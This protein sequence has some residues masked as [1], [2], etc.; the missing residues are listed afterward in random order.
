[1]LKVVLQAVGKWSQTTKS[2]WKEELWAIG[3]GT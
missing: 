1:M 3:K 2:K